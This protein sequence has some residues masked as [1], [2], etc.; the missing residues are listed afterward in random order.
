MAIRVGVVGAGSW[1]TTIASMAA[2]NTSTMLWAR[3]AVTAEVINAEHRNPAYLGR[4]ELPT[5]LIA[6]HDLEEVVRDADVV[7]MAVPSQGFREVLHAAAAHVRRG[8]PIVSVAKGLE[9]GSLMRMSEVI[10][11]ELPGH[12]AAVLTGPNLAHEIM[13]GQPAASVVAIDDE[14]IARELQRIFSNPRLLI[15]TNPDVV[16]CEVSGVV[17]NVIAIA[18]GMAGGMGFGNNT[19]ATLITRGL[20]EMTRLGTAMG[21]TPATFAGLAGMGDLIATCSSLQSR[22]TS[23]GMALGRGENI[24]DVVA[25]MQMVAEGVKS[26]AAVLDLAAQ[27][28]IEMPITEQVVAVCHGGISAEQALSDLLSRGGRSEL[29]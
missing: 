23:V 28:G 17:K 16:G 25:S 13:D 29:D 27:F 9:Q 2:L 24:G 10:A 8:V 6:S 12:P 21:G 7:V 4:R 22:N 1:G 26:S 18:A 5:E 19:R 11:S 14:T 3:S 20:A 15:Y